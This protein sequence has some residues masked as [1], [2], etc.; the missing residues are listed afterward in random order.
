[1]EAR[2]RKKR[3]Q[4]RVMKDLV[5]DVIFDMD[6]D[7][8]CVAGPPK[9]RQYPTDRKPPTPREILVL[10]EE[11]IWYK[12]YHHP[13]APNPESYMGSCSGSVFVSLGGAL[14]GSKNVSSKRDG[15]EPRMSTHS[16]SSLIQ[17][18]FD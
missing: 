16:G 11:C 18:P 4:K 3:K 8:A 6:S 1:M 7:D 5:V 9:K 14:V 2:R 12:H 13:D 17:H 10:P 15:K